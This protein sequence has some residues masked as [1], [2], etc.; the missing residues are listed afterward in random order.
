M[1]IIFTIAL[2][3]DLQ[4]HHMHFLIKDRH[5][6]LSY[7]FVHVRSCIT[8]P[9]WRHPAD[10]T[11]ALQFCAWSVLHHISES[12]TSGLRPFCEL[13]ADKPKVSTFAVAFLCRIS[14]TTRA[15]TIMPAASLISQQQQQQRQQHYFLPPPQEHPYTPSRKNCCN[16]TIKR[17][18]QRHMTCHLRNLDVP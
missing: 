7:S 3:F 10:Q 2:S 18:K 13:H 1:I 4:F 9:Y 6:N 8:S 17:A 15:S 11:I 14:L 12:K 5:Q 16:K